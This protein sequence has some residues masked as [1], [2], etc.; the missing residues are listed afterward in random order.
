MSIKNPYSTKEFRRK[1]RQ[2]ST[3]PE[4]ALWQELRNR[5]FNGL[6]FKRQFGVGPYVLDFYCPE[7]N[8]CIEL[9][10][11]IHDQPEQIVHDLNRDKFLNRNGIKVLRIKNKII[12]EELDFALALISNEISDI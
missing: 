7:K 11:S 2:K 4:R 10:G 12:M 9:D 8:F 1:L 6:K 5:K 3:I